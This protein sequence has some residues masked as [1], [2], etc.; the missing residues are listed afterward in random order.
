MHGVQVIKARIQWMEYGLWLD[1][2]DAALS[3][4]SKADKKAVE[5]R[6]VAANDDAERLAQRNYETCVHKVLNGDSRIGHRVLKSSGIHAPCDATVDLMASKFVRSRSGDTLSADAE[7]RARARKCKAPKIIEVVVGKVIGNT[8]DCKA[9][10]VSGWRNS[11]LKAIVSTPEGSGAL[12]EWVNIWV[13]GA[14]PE[15]MAHCWRAVL[16]VPLRKAE[17]DVRPILLGE[18]L[19]SLLGA[20]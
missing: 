14:V 7:L 15:I 6:I 12:W 19:L 13:S 1:E 20:C 18:A 16:G 17:I 4:V 9:A 3:D 8:K 2:I 10:G 11:R 5:R